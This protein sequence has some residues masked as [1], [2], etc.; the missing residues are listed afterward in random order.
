METWWFLLLEF[1]VA[2]CL[3]LLS[4]RQ[5]F[6]G[7]SK[8]F[9]FILIIIAFLFA[10]GETAPR[11]TSVNAHIAVLLTLGSFGLFR[12]VRNMLV[13]RE[14]VIVAP[15]AGV[16]FSVAVTAFMSNQWPNLSTVEE[17]FAFLMIVVIGLCQVWLVFRGLLIGRLPLAWS[18]AGLFA[19]Q[20]GQVTNERGAIACF[21][22]AWDL[23][24]EHLNPMAWLALHKI[25]KFLNNSDEAKHYENRLKESGGE[26]AI[27]PEWIQTID[28]ALSDLNG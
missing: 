4:P 17:I 1:S 7:P 2:V 22:K 26:E 18:K 21:E 15:F 3:L 11:P 24:E 12:G 9:G 16:L 28:S 14:E 13:T 25:H 6:P 8:R 27:A 19:L 5:P 20:K 10:I 23:E